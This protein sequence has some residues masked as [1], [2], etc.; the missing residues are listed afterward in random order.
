M[1]T[2]KFHE[3]IRL[4][5]EGKFFECHDLF[6][7]IWM[8][9]EGSDAEFFRALIHLAVGCYHM[10][11]GNYRGAKSQLI[12]GTQK[13]KPYEPEHR[14]ILISPLVASFRDIIL[15]VERVLQGHIKADEIRD[16]PMMDRSTKT[17]FQ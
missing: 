8:S 3:G 13:L 9:E 6:E 4:F 14:E 15:D 17:R 5:N 2:E 1:K 7:E 10:K 12:K 16:V 11:N